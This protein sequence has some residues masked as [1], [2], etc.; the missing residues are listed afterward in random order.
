MPLLQWQFRHW[1]EGRLV[2]VQ[3]VEAK[4]GLEIQNETVTLASISY[5]NFFRSYP[6][7]RGL[8][9]QS[10]YTV[11]SAFGDPQLPWHAHMLPGCSDSSGTL[12]VA[13]V[14][15]HAGSAL[16]THAGRA[17]GACY[18]SQA[19]PLDTPCWQVAGGARRNWR[20]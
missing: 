13:E 12:L 6:V 3:A 1:P 2:A 20:A 4:E 18:C 11:A 9:L 19:V 15:L 10:L 8:L 16:G 14:T 7:R 5:Q 17:A